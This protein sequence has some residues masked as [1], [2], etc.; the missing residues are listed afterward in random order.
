MAA[1]PEKQRA[2]DL[3]RE[4]ADGE[5]R[6]QHRRIRNWVTERRDG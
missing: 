4:S 1:A 3:G 2:F 5:F 6:R